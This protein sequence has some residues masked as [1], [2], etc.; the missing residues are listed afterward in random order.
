MNKFGQLV[1]LQNRPQ[2][3]Q[4]QEELKSEFFQ[5]RLDKSMN[6]TFPAE[7][8]TYPCLAASLATVNDVTRIGA[9]AQ[10]TVSC[11]FVYPKDAERLQD[12]VRQSRTDWNPAVDALLNE[13]DFDALEDDFGP[14]DL[15]TLVLALVMELRELGAVK[16]DRLTGT[17]EKVRDW[18]ED[19]MEENLEEEDTIQIL[20]KLW[21]A[22]NAG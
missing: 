5:D 9:L 10:A 20:E 15:G 6:L 7:P 4:Y 3:Q 21:K 22:H 8:K 11:C 2:W 18:L 19:N 1:V 13:E 17:M 14:S 12:V 16:L